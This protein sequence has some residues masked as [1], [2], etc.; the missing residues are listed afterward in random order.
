MT[1]CTL[2]M[3]RMG[4]SVASCV[5]ML[6]TSIVQELQSSIEKLLIPFRRG[7]PSEKKEEQSFRFTGLDISSTEDGITVKQ[8]EYR[9]SLEEIKIGDKKDPNRELNPDK[10]KQF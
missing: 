5:C 3:M 9:D 8:N 10:Y 6:T 2:I 1:R 7:S 4:I